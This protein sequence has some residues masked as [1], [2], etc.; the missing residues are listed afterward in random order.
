VGVTVVKELFGS[1]NPVGEI[2]KINLVNFKVIGILLR[3]VPAAR[4]RTR[5]I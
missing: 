3:R 5:M 4:S 2:I 1:S